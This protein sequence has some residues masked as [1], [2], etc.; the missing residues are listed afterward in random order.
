MNPEFFTLFTW[1]VLIQFTFYVTSH[2]PTLSQIDW[3]AAFVGRTYYHDNSNVLSGILV[4]SNIFCGVI[5]FGLMYPMLIIAPFL[6]HVKYPEFRDM[7]RKQKKTDELSS[8]VAGKQK[9]NARQSTKD[10]QAPD[11][12]IESLTQNDEDAVE[13][14]GVGDGGFDVTRGE[15]NLYE[16]E[17]CLLVTGFRVAAK[18]LLLQGFRVSSVDRLLFVTTLSGKLR[19]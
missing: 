9:L 6:I 7:F 1:S 18:L 8:S 14:D 10:D 4:L 16:N 15:L 12:K 13:E 17:R 5:L 19:T 3:H 2:Q 11:Y